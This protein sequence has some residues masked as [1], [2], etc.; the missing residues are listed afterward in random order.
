MVF[1]DRNAAGEVEAVY[2]I[3]FDIHDDVVEREAL[4]ASRQRLDRFTEHIPYP[5]TYVDREFRLRF[6]PVYCYAVFA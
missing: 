6:V 3:A 5:L 2:T 1:P 4:V